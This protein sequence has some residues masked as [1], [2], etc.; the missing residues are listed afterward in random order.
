MW[1]Q[2]LHAAE[3][4]ILKWLAHQRRDDYWRRGSVGEHRTFARDW[5]RTIPRDCL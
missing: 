1:Y 2:R 3:P 5:E 4:W